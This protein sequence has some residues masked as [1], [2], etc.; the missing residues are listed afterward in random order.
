MR[1]TETSGLPSTDSQVRP[2]F[3]IIVRCLLFAGIFLSTTIFGCRHYNTQQ[4]ESD[5]TSAE[6]KKKDVLIRVN[7][8]LVDDDA[9]EIEAFAE[10]NGWEMK[11]TESGLR[12]MIYRHGQGE[13]AV[14]GK[15]AELAYT[16]SLLDG[17]VCYSSDRSGLKT[18]R[19]GQGGVE[20]GLEEGVLLM[21]MGDKARFIMLPHLA[22]GLSGDGDRIPPRAI[23]VYDVELLHLK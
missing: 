3:R 15:L 14:T 2:E 11:T 8:E 21:R 18:F 10:R 22:H 5:T 12:Y 1:K 4:P 6:R 17:T 23:I 20:S 19:L 13:K 9:K 16:V 7:R